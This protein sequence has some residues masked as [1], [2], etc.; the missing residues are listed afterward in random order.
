M[1][2][3]TPLLLLMAIGTAGLVWRWSRE[4]AEIAECV[5]QQAEAL[6]GIAGVELLTQARR[7]WRGFARLAR[8]DA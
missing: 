8:G 6:E 4:G 1:D 2:Q 3:F 5:E 7:E